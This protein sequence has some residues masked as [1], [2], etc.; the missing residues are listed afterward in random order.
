ML[1]LLAHVTFANVVLGESMLFFCG[2]YT[3]RLGHVDGQAR[4]IRVYALDDDIGRIDLRGESP[5]VANSSHLCLGP[6]G[7]FLYAISEITKFN[8]RDDG[9]LTV[10]ALD[11][12][13]D[14]LKAIQVTS[15]HGP[16]PA[17]VHLD[18]SG[19]FLMLANYV[20]G[21]VVVFPILGD[22]KL[23]PPTADMRHAGHGVNELRQEGPHPHAIVPSP[24]NRFVFVPDLG[25]DRIVAYR[26]DPESGALTRA[27][28]DARTPRGSG[29]RHLVFSPDGEHAYCS[30]E[31]T[32][33]IA[34]FDYDSGRLSEIGRWS[35]LPDGYAG[36]NTCAEVRITPDGRHV[37]VSNRGHD[38]L[39]AFAVDAETGALR[40]IE[41]EPS[42][43]RTPR[44]FGVSPNGKWLVV[45]N[46]DSN[47]LAAFKR[48]RES[49]R[50]GASGEVVECP[51]PALIRFAEPARSTI[52]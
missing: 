19:R 30:L 42:R 38:S 32:S 4:A 2:T 1:M 34:A 51:S 48:E 10:F 21:N 52:R 14:G 50:L 9:C 26:F 27:G 39:A 5:E 18:R 46:Q 41:T 35:T 44:N 16:G 6:Q 23:G 24:D 12:P 40:F 3:T 31:L 37:Y 29:P 25:V 49:G 8:G 33:E 13:A 45:A 47:G 17:Y 22:G 7:K 36:T 43:G 20:A 15:S 28:D 11:E